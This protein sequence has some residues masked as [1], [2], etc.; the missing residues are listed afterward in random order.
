MQEQLPE[1]KDCPRCGSGMKLAEKALYFE[2]AII[3]NGAFA[4]SGEGQPL[5]PYL[6]LNCGY[7]EFY[8]SPYEGTLRRMFPQS[9]ES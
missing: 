1:L 8:A 4:A 7:I 3:K 5:F 9:S 6:C 2:T